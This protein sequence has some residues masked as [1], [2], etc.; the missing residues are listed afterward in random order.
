MITVSIVAIAQAAVFA[1]PLGVPLRVATER[2]EGEW[3]FRM[4]RLVR[5]TRE[6]SGY[7]AEVWITAADGDGPNQISAMMEAGFGGLSGRTIVF[8]LDAA[9]KVTGI[10]DIDTVW[11]RFCDGIA[12]I[13]KTRHKDADRLIGPIRALPPERRLSMLAS[14]VTTLI[15][16]E[17]AEPVGTRPVRLPGS[18]PYG[19]QITLT[20]TRG[21]DRLGIS[22]R[23]TTRTSA[24][25]PARN[26][27]TGTIEMELTRVSDPATGMISIISERVRTRI[28][29]ANRERLSTIRVTAE[30]ATA[31]PG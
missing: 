26:G 27:A 12:T 29:S 4:E 30:P 6:G 16:G 13:V 10:D 28:G 23:S 20:G 18:S 11:G 1:P 14:L 3:T 8:H 22:Q 15:A 7:R 2:A 24:D 9:G 21:I 17:A 31:W 25:L 5:F 19:G